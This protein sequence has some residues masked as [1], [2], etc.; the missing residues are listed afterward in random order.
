MSAPPLGLFLGDAISSMVDY[1]HA[2]LPLLCVALGLRLVALGT[3]LAVAVVRARERREIVIVRDTTTI[4]IRGGGDPDRALHAFA[5]V[6]GAAPAQD[7]AFADEPR[8]RRRRA[9][10]PAG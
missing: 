9:R 6:S 4:I 7:A 8:Y 10:R 2:Y 3:A 5:E 1:P